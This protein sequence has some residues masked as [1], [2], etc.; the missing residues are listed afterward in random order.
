MSYDGIHSCHVRFGFA[1]TY[2]LVTSK[3]LLWINLCNLIYFVLV[4]FKLMQWLPSKCY[5]GVCNLID[6]ICMI[7]LCRGVSGLFQVGLKTVSP[8]ISDIA[9]L[10]FSLQLQRMQQMS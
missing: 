10:Y 9:F 8:P 5:C 6:N 4:L 3:V 7:D 1:G 2:T